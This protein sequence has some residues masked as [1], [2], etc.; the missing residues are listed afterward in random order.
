MKKNF[1]TLLV[2]LTSS[3]AFA[4]TPN[5]YKQ[6]LKKQKDSEW[7]AFIYPKV[8]IECANKKNP[9]Y[10]KYKQLA[11]ENGFKSIEDFVKN[12]CL[13]IAKELYYTVDEANGRNLRSIDY[14]L[15]EGGYLSY[16]D[17]NLPNITIGFDM[18]YLNKFSQTHND[19]TSADEIYGVLCHEIC[20]GYQ[21]EPKGTDRYEDKGESFAF[22]EGTSD[23]ARLLTGGF[24]P[25]RYPKVGGTWLDGYNTTGFFYLWILRNKDKNFLK[26]LNKTALTMEHWSFAGA[27]K[28]L[29]GESAT[30]LWAAYQKDIPHF[31]QQ[32]KEGK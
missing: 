25:P 14:K 8:T 16:K 15:T 17:G 10:L 13:V 28:E 21:R 30:E 9:G 29:F 23:L 22:M 11:K 2:L 5:L 31:A 12:C 26:D 27:I 18:D 20:H 1:I 24:N 32:L 19:S 6:N 3:L 7:A 4:A